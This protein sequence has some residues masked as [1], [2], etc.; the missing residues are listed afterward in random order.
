MKLETLFCVVTVAAIGVAGPAMT[1]GKTFD[2]IFPTTSSI[3]D[4]CGSIPGNTLASRNACIDSAQTDYDYDRVVW[5][6]LSPPR[7]EACGELWGKYAAT[8]MSTRSL[9]RAIQGCLTNQMHEQDR[10]TVHRFQHW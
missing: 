6:A 8:K 9:Y 10:E 3:E 4:F 5:G 1:T 7:R 2:E